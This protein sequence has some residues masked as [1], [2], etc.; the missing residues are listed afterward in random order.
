MKYVL[1]FFVSLSLFVA[2]NGFGA[3][4]RELLE[5]PSPSIR[6]FASKSLQGTYVPLSRTN[7]EELIARLQFGMNESAVSNLLSSAGATNEG[8]EKIRDEIVKTFRVDDLWVIRCWFTNAVAT[9]VVVTNSVTKKAVT[10]NVVAGKS[11]YGLA[12]ARVLEQMN[13]IIV[14]PPSDFSGIWLTYWINGNV[15]YERHFQ[16]GQLEGVNTGFYPNGVRSIEVAF[17]NGVP[18]GQDTGYFPSGKI[19]YQGQNKAGKEVGHWIW[20]SEGGVVQAERDYDAKG[21]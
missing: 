9:N 10:K 7:A 16:N 6:M 3:T 5:S 11:E 18:D 17:H 12:E 19:Q 14:D 8:V 1:Q 21:K 20:Y 2:V 4:A 13:Q 15:S